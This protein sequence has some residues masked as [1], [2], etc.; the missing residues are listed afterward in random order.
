MRVVGGPCRRA[1]ARRSTQVT[2][3]GLNRIII[4]AELALALVLAALT[5]VFGR[6]DDEVRPLSKPYARD[7]LARMIS[8]LLGAKDG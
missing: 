5:G 4:A 2:R 6:L 7:D 8:E 1:W 3:L